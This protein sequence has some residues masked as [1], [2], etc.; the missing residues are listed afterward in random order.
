[1]PN[2]CPPGGGGKA[3]GGRIQTTFDVLNE[4]A[5]GQ[6]HSFG[7]QHPFLC[8]LPSKN[9][10]VSSEAR[11]R[12]SI[13][14]LPVSMSAMKYYYINALILKRAIERHENPSRQRVS[15]E[16]RSKLWRVSGGSTALTDSQ[17]QF[18]PYMVFCDL[19][20]DV[21]GLLF[22]V[23]VKMKPGA[24]TYPGFMSD[25]GRDD[26]QPLPAVNVEQVDSVSVVE[27]QSGEAPYF[28]FYMWT[29]SPKHCKDVPVLVPVPPT[30][31]RIRGPIDAPGGGAP[32]SDGDRERV[33]VPPSPRQLERVVSERTMLAVGED[34]PM[35]SVANAPVDML[36]R[37]SLSGASNASSL[38][39]KVGVARERQAG[40]GDRGFCAELRA[41]LRS[42][43]YE[44]A[45]ARQSGGPRQSAPSGEPAAEASSEG[46][47]GERGPLEAS[48]DRGSDEATR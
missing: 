39:S 44:A 6:A 17:G 15:R 27:G 7:A 2:E 32:T 4:H 43:L 25:G 16:Y 8:V 40:A 11:L 29:A 48:A 28:G 19:Q 37:L 41:R 14:S 22:L 47:R 35:L 45:A 20:V 26:V 1:M 3:S 13:P 31:P 46:R 12:H 10:F 24:S 23:R 21:L 34:S 9:R 38:F 33:E 36:D 42:M 18:S 30:E 5:Q